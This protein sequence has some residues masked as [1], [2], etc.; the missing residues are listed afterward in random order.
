MNEVGGGAAFPALELCHLCKSFGALE[1]VQNLSLK[2]PE[3]RTLALIGPSGCGKST[4]LNLVSGLD[5][6]Y[7]GKI[8]L[9]GR[10]LSRE[11]GRKTGTNPHVGYMLQKDLLLPWRNI[12]QN[13]LLPRELRHLPMHSRART[14]ELFALFGL[15]SFRKA[16]PSQLSG[17]MRQRANLLRTYTI[18]SDLLLLDEP[19]GAL[20]ALTRQSLQYWFLRM[21]R[22]HPRSILFVTH[23]IREAILLADQV[24]VLSMRPCREVTCFDVRSIERSAE[25]EQEIF[26]CLDV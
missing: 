12:E 19:F 7:G 2:L 10:E 24:M 4:V 17:G 16:Y 3:H 8:R 14:E 20:D 18:K 1:V 6:E 15:E 5:P 9:F 22:E 13:V 11:S 25:L 21:N 26:S 23:D